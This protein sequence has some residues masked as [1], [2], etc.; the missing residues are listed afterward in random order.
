MG[1]NHPLIG[2]PGEAQLQKDLTGQMLN[3]KERMDRVEG[4]DEKS[5]LTI[6]YLES[7]ESA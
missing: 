1:R 5:D 7:G 3:Y 2:N 4:K 6:Q